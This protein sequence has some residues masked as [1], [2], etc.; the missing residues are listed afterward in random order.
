M[1]CRRQQGRSLLFPPTECRPTEGP[2]S[3]KPQTG[4]QFPPLRQRLVPE[5]AGYDATLSR[6]RNGFNSRRDRTWT[7]SSATRT[8][9][10]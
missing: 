10:S 3:Y 5:S 2:W 1:T 4:V 9:G 8:L 6:W 7:C